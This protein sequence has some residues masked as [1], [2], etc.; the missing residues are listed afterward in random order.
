ME[1]TFEGKIEKKNSASCDRHYMNEPVLRV[2]NIYIISIKKI[3][4]RY[5]KTNK[6]NIKKITG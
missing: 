6:V 5:F 2:K 3:I 4:L 1:V